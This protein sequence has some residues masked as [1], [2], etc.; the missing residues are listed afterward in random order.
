MGRTACSEQERRR[1]KKNGEGDDATK[2]S[3][4]SIARKPIKE[5]K[6]KEQARTPSTT[7][8]GRSIDMTCSGQGRGGHLMRKTFRAKPDG[9]G[10]T[11]IREKGERE[12]DAKTKVVYSSRNSARHGGGM[13]F[14][15]YKNISGAEE[16]RVKYFW[17]EEHPVDQ[18][19]NSIQ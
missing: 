1:R 14:K 9:K 11:Q 15:L 17:R 8:R 16:G 12:D 5:G 6:L 7:L 4:C 19:K 10:T 13:T 3:T 2:Y 18:W